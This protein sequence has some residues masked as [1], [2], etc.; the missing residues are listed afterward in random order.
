MS[1]NS[2]REG[3]CERCDHPK[4][5]HARKSESKCKNK[6]CGKQWEICQGGVHGEVQDNLRRICYKPCNCKEKYYPD[7]V[8]FALPLAPHEYKI[9][10]PGYRA[11]S[12]EEEEDDEE[13]VLCRLNISPQLL[14]LSKQPISPSSESSEDPLSCSE[15][16][17][18]EMPGI[19]DG[20]AQ[21]KIASTLPTASAYGPV[22]TSSYSQPV[23]YTSANSLSYG[24]KASAPNPT[25]TLATTSTSTPAQAA[26]KVDITSYKVKNDMCWAFKLDGK[27]ITS[28]AD[29]WVEMT[30][31]EVPI[32]LYKDHNVYFYKASKK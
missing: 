27:M 13:E 2:G 25:D 9:G 30:L 14:A 22:S 31:N 11:L 19:A 16:T 21:M 32:M 3:T 6:A 10:H 5:G 26:R 23:G 7:K 28:W 8:K 17:M 24:S 20:M 29:K 12:Q 4:D 1:T 15:R 18:G